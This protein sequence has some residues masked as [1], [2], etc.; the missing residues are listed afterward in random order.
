MK[1]RIFTIALGVALVMVVLVGTVSA[2]GPGRGRG[3]PNGTVLTWSGGTEYA[4]YLRTGSGIVHQ[5]RPTAP[6]TSQPAWDWHPSISMPAPRTV[7]S[8][9]RT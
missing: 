1:K 8:R 5:W 4:W 2:G 3:G 9:N 6:V 7:L